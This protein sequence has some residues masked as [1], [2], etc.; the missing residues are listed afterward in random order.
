[1]LQL[2]AI[3]EVTTNWFI[4]YPTCEHRSSAALPLA[5]YTMKLP[6]R[7]EEAA[8]QCPRPSLFGQQKAGRCANRV[9]E[10]SQN[11]TS[12]ELGVLQHGRL[13]VRCALGSRL[14]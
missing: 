5:V 2:S 13:L 1:M 9:T 3:I 7:S 12:E 6:Q 11:L 8:A 14:L 10:S 4:I